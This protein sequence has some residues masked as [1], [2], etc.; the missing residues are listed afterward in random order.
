MFS[1]QF[2]TRIIAG[3]LVLSGVLF[4]VGCDSGGTG[5]TA[6]GDLTL[7]LT[8]AP[9][10]LDSAVV[11]V[12]RVDLLTEDG[13]SDDGNGDDDDS[14]D[15][16]DGST[17]TLTDETRQL[18]LLQLQNGN[19]A[20]L[21]D[22]V[23]VPEGEYTQLRFVLGSENYVVVNGEQQML[24]VPSGQ[25]SGIKIVLPEV[26]IEND[27]DQI[28]LTLDFDVEDSF[29]EQGNG[30]YRF[31]P[32]IKVKNV[33][34][35]GQ[36]IETVSVDG[37]VTGVG[38]GNN[39]ISVED[40]PFTTTTATEIE[41]DN[42]ST[43]EDF[44]EGQYVAVEGTLLDDGTVE[45]REI[46]TEESDDE[47]SITARIE[48]KT[49]TEQEQSLTLLGVAIQVTS[50]TEFDDNSLDALETGDRVEVDYTVDSDGNRLATQ[51]ENEGD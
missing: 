5:S 13:V 18:D 48:S 16:D 7:R 30:T 34:V 21:A 29:V 41:G 47:R 2:L 1:T 50:N 23:T 38:A 28:D 22:E 39:E 37:L 43:L 17:L 12:D 32:T 45:A 19:E 8:D 3:A 26:E 44:S 6:Q 31:K 14:G 27:G 40:I 4:W 25:Q 9:A 20:L 36:S 42:V 35:N 33:F 49:N 10:D 51:I 46:E 11:T 15:D 24:E